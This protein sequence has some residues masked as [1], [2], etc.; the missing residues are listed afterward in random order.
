MTMQRLAFDTYLDHIR[1]ESS[2]FH[3]VLAGCRP[4]ARVPACPDWDAADLLW[5]LTTVQAF[6]TKII[7]TRPA[8][9][10]ESDAGR[11]ERPGS[12]EALLT[13]FEVHSAALVEALAAADPHEEAWH[14]SSEHT[15]GASYRRQAHEA[16]IHRLDAEETADLVTPLD[17]ALA[18]DGV[19]EALTVMFGD[20]PPWG[21][22]T[23]SDRAV[24]V[25]MTDTGHRLLVAL[26]RFTGTDPDDGVTYDE[27]DIAVVDAATPV[28][29]VSGTA[30]DLDAW[31][32]H[33]G[34]GRVHVHVDGDRGAYD[35]LAAILKQPID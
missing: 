3:E 11:L 27:P 10:E 19:H 5:H 26:A 22:I 7:T 34:S 28:A 1:T 24:A 18:A 13:A 21:T 31:L 25:E 4:Q 30:A 8:P 9:A 12:Y 16:L 35:E 14:W 32:W 15:V 2:R 17:A 23:P 20:C 29:T 33:R 6:W